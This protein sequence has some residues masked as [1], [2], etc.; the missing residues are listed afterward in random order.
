MN[1]SI[2]QPG[3]IATII[4]QLLPTLFN[5]NPQNIEWMH[6]VCQ[7]CKNLGNKPDIR[8]YYTTEEWN[9]FYEEMNKIIAQLPPKLYVAEGA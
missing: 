2:T 9:I 6:F 7:L 1:Y 4:L 8:K 3:V 5:K